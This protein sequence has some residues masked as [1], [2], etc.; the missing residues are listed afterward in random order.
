MITIM[1]PPH[2]SGIYLEAFFLSAPMLQRL[3]KR[4]VKLYFL[5]LN[6]KWKQGSKL[7]DALCSIIVV[8]GWRWFLY[9]ISCR[10]IFKQKCQTGLSKSSQPQVKW[11]RTWQVAL[12]KGHAWERNLMGQEEPC[13]PSQPGD[14]PVKLLQ[15]KCHRT[16][17]LPSGVPIQVSM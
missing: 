14:V 3:E 9:D 7:M 5:I 8:K 2:P 17:H 13:K 6:W 12:R 10:R 1:C 16:S 15:T 11:W 4:S